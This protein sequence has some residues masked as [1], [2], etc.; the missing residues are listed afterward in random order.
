MP[1]GVGY[2]PQNT[3]SISKT[4]FNVLGNHLYA[5]NGGVD[6]GNQ[7]VET[8][9]F[10]AETGNYYSKGWLRFTLDHISGDNV[11][12]AVYFNDVIIWAEQSVS[13]YEG[14]T[15]WPLHIVIPPFT[16]V[17]LTGKNTASSTGRRVFTSITGRI[18]K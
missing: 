2:G 1:V 9:L 13:G 6:T 11:E 18:Y 14:Y 5:L 12:V 16:T 4:N 15:D 7:N 10:K 8:T 17:K 3:A